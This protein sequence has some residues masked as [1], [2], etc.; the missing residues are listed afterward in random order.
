MRHAKRTDENHAAIVAEIRTVLPDATLL[1]L[2][3]SG[4]GCPDVCIGWKGRNWFYE[5]KNPGQPPSKRKLT[6]MQSELHQGWQGHMAVAHSA[7]EI[8]ADLARNSHRETG[9]P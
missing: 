5:L 8:C 2:S 1:D 9:K 6:P 3:G 4:K 7:A